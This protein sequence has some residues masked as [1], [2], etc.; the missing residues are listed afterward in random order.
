MRTV[1]I[2]IGKNCF[3]VAICEERG[4][5]VERARA[6]EEGSGGVHYTTTTEFDRNGVVRWLTAAGKGL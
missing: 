6:D 5:V 2:D 3:H 4:K 1:G